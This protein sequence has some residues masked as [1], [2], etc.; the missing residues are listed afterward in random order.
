MKNFAPKIIAAA[1]LLGL[2]LLVA[3]A[4][5]LAQPTGG[6]DGG[7]TGGSTGGFTGGSTGGFTG[8]GG[9]CNS[10]NN[11]TFTLCNPLAVDNFCDL[12]KAVLN[13]IL[14]LGVPIA[15]LF[16]VWSGFRFIFARGRPAELDAAKRNFMYV[17]IGIAVFL[18]AWTLATIISA[19]IQQLDSNGNIKICSR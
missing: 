16:L 8:G 4:T 17:I 14:A 9:N 19:T 7:F 3:P 15:V 12:I 10:V 5:S 13:V 6:S 2:C 11:G 18:G 1:F